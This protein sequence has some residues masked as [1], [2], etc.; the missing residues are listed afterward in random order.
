M[1]IPLTTTQLKKI[2]ISIVLGLIIGAALYWIQTGYDPLLVYASD[3]PQ[4]SNAKI[5]LDDWG[6]PSSQFLLPTG[7]GK[8][9]SSLMTIDQAADPPTYGPAA[10]LQE[11]LGDSVIDVSLAYSGMDDLIE[12]GT[13]R[14][15]ILKE[16]N[17]YYLWLNSM[18]RPGA[19][20]NVW[21]IEQRLESDDGLIWRNRTDTNLIRQSTAYKFIT[22]LHEI[23]KTGDTYEAWE[24][25][26]Y[27]WSSGWAQSIRY[28]TSN[29][30]LNWTVVTEPALIGAVF[31][32]VIKDGNT[33]HMWVNPHGDSHYTGTRS[34]R[35]RTST[36]GGSGWGHWQTGGTLVQ[37][38]GNN[39]VTSL[40][41]VR[42]LPDRTYQ[43]FYFDGSKINVATS[44]DAIN[45]TTQ[46]VGLLDINEVLPPPLFSL[47]DFAVVEVEG[48]DWFYFNYCSETFPND[49]C[50]EGK[51]AVSRPIVATNPDTFVYLPVILRDTRGLVSP[52]LTVAS[53]AATSNNVTLTIKNVGTAPAVDNFYVVAYIDPSIPPTQDYKHWSSV[54]EE[55]LVWIITE[56][57]D[58]DDSLTLTIDDTH[59]LPLDSNFNGNWPVNTPIYAQVD[60]F[61]ES[62]NGNVLELDEIFVTRPYN[63]IASTLSK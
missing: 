59:Y 34:L 19:I 35:Y 10:I 33:Y 18:I 49:R 24:Q 55:G 43:L 25:Y 26:Y 41:R 38:D 1:S 16:D 51:V 47:R 39:E 37:V 9:S 12:R 53:L 61:I 20:N 62:T 31:H 29:D 40:N 56:S 52:D 22:G 17:T 48:E 60:A 36:N 2:L 11:D 50:K 44:T 32:S 63:N 23:I 54:S 30:G 57:L 46:I 5:T 45:F 58:V 28:M 27:E 3:P 7:Q 6:N 15:N 8:A 4:P 14:F 42:Q 21:S 13:Y